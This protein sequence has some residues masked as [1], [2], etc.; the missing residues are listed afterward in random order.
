MELS[1]LPDPYVITNGWLLATVAIAACAFESVWRRWFGGGFK[2]E[3]Y[4]FLDRRIIKHIVNI[5]FIFAIMYWVRGLDI[6]WTVITVGIMEGLYWSL[7]HGPYFDLGRG[8]MPDE[9]MK[10]RYNK[11]F[12]HY[13][14]DWCFSEE[15]R[16]TTFYD[17]CGMLIRYT[18]PL[19]LMWIVP[20][21]N[22][23]ITVLGELV[24]VAYAV[25]WV[26]RDKKLLKK[27]GAT[28]LGEYIAGGLTGLFLVL[29]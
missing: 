15:E 14:L 3:T 12:Y 13:I 24:A 7:G 22:L 27:L 10:K 6:L 25:C 28:D 9:K 26:A 20:G 23:G 18:W 8:G 19:L 1:W 29:V 11:M 2:S 4:K 16:Y 17:F 5:V 21:F